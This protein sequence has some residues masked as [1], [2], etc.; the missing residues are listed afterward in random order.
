MS[1]GFDSF[2]RHCFF[3]VGKFV[4]RIFRMAKKGPVSLPFP[5]PPMSA[6]A[7]ATEALRVVYLP[8]LLS[9]F[10]SSCGSP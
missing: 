2:T 1:S 3:D 6:N 8:A 7:T 5:E 4:G 10:S 9:R